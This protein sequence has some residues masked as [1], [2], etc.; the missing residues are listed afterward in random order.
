MTQM[1][2][3]DQLFDHDEGTGVHGDCYRTCLAMILGFTSPNEVPHL[4]QISDDTPEAYRE[5]EAA[6]NE[7]L[8][9]RGYVPLIVDMSSDLSFDE[10]VGTVGSRVGVSTPWIAGVYSSAGTNHAIV[11]RGARVFHNPSKSRVLGP[12]KYR[13]GS[14]RWIATFL[15]VSGCYEDLAGDTDPKSYISD[16]PPELDW[17]I[18][19]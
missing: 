14:S 11:C 13:D 2:R 7:F 19:T 18:A 6:Y 8:S 10:F 5:A 3:L 9:S 12:A 1:H 15:A 16:P 4:Y 17:R